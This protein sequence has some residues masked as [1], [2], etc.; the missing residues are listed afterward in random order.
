VSNRSPHTVRCDDEEWSQF[1]AWVEEKEGQ[2]HGEIGRHLEYAI[3]EYTNNDRGHRLEENQKEVKERL[4]EVVDLLTQNETTHT[5]TTRHG[6]ESIEKVTEIHNRVVNNNGEAIKADVVELAI[7]DIAG[8]DPRT[9]RKYK[10]I[11][12]KRGLLYEHPGN[13]ALW[14]PDVE[15]WMDW[16][17][18]TANG[19]DNL[20]EICDP[21]PAI[22]HGRGD[23][24]EIE[25]QE[26]GV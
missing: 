18:K 16:C 15:K 4:D 17:K 2:K 23:G 26:V 6:S 22:V 12:R 5:H 13:R 1:V 10:N 19:R 21:Y 9:V 7:G 14:T 25:A 20:E 24:L 8:H 3:K 11:L